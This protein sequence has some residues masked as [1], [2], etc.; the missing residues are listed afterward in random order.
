[1][2]KANF[3][4]VIFIGQN[5]D[6]SFYYRLTY[7]SFLSSTDSLESELFMLKSSR[8]EPCNSVLCMVDRVLL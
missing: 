1:L 7:N 2:L 5:F 8:A 4:V 3:L 6:I